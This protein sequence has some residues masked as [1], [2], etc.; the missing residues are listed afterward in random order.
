M[1]E[2]VKSWVRQWWWDRQWARQGRGRMDKTSTAFWRICV[3][4]SH[5]G[6]T[7]CCVIP[8]AYFYPSRKE[9][10]TWVPRAWQTL[11]ASCSSSEVGTTYFYLRWEE[12]RAICQTLPVDR[13]G[14]W[15]PPVPL[16]GRNWIW[17]TWYRHSCCRIWQE[18][19]S[20]WLSLW[21]GEVFSTAVSGLKLLIQEL[22]IL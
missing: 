17:L 6:A 20:L 7:G 5:S 18:I 9:L 8:H 14:E 1:R 16:K 4:V 3:D 11:Q 19:Y 21:S 22:V 2:K 13:E 12:R 10:Q 15:P